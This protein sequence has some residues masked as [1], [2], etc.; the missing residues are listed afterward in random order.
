MNKRELGQFGEDKAAQYLKKKGYKIIERNFRYARGEIDIIA[1]DGGYIVFIEVKLR[2]SFKYG[3]PES[4]VDT[5]KQNKIRKVAEYFL[6]GYE[7]G[8]KIRF[9]VISIQIEDGRGRLKHY[10][11]AF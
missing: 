2:R 4:A 7:S 9:D 3:L 8:K 5:R 10:K 11:N 1:S 6:L